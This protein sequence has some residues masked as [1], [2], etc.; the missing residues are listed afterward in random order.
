MP[1]DPVCACVQVLSSVLI[2]P[3]S[4]VNCLLRMKMPAGT[5]LTEQIQRAITTWLVVRAVIGVSAEQ[6]RGTYASYEVAVVLL[7]PS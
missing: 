2:H 3:S 1:M 7:A 6:G 4:A 5:R